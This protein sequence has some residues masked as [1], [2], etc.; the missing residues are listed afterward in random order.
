MHT[1]SEK[2]N[3][4]NL[5][6]SGPRRGGTRLPTAAWPPPGGGHYPLSAAPG[7]GPLNRAK[8]PSIWVGGEG[9]LH[10]MDDPPWLDMNIDMR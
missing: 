3:T 2:S 10:A 9:L 7:L 4:K 8:N 6:C 1:T 5:S